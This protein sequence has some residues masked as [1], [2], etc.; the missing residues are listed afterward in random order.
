VNAETANRK[1]D[2]LIAAERARS[3]EKDRAESRARDARTQKSLAETKKRVERLEMKLE[4]VA[5]ARPKV[6]T[7]V[8]YMPAKAVKVAARKPVVA[9][10][11]SEKEPP[12]WNWMFGMLMAPRHRGRLVT[13]N[14]WD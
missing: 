6:V 1:L 7:V 14:N 12:G 13:L 2:K 8:R 11:P 3:R 10:R 4:R 5:R 9:A